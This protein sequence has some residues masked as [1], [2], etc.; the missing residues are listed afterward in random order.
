MVEITVLSVRLGDG[1][2]QVG[3][4]T[5]G[6]RTD[7]DAGESD[8]DAGESDDDAG[9]ESD[10]DTGGGGSPGRRIATLLLAVG[11]AALL[12]ALIARALG[13]DEGLE[14]LEELEELADE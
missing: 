3:P 2:I 6:G 13:D 8:A 11:V 14:E 10:D 7:A 1:S 5:L 12:V 4:K 9:D